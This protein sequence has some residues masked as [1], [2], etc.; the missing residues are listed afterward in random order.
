[1]RIAALTTDTAHHRYWAFR[2]AEAGLLGTVVLETRRAVAPFETHH[3]FEDERDEYER[4]AL[5]APAWRELA[6]VA[7]VESVDDARFDG[8]LAIS[9]GTGLIGPQLVS[10]WAGRLLNLHGGD[11]EDYRGLDTHLW[12]VYHGDFAG[13]VTTLHEVDV[14]LDTGAIVGRAPISL[15]AELHELRAANTE[16][17]IE[18]SLQAARERPPATPQRRRGRYYSFMPSVLKDTC[19]RRWSRRSTP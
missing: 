19:V 2:L 18:L 3:P 9:F 7:E 15:P 13:L 6:P 1:V 10:A 11:P 12:A 5:A 8:D 14:G 17:C 16:V 4:A